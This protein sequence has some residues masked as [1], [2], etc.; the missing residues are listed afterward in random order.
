MTRQI[1]VRLPDDIADFIDQMVSEGREKSR[2]AV[3]SR[4]VER[5][6]R[7]ELAARDAQ[8]LSRVGSGDDLDDLASYAAS[9]PVDVE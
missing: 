8:I 1:A 7:R 4:A 9:T 2:A 6:R 3:V 5:E